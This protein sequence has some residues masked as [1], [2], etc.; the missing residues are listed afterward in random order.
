ML[1]RRRLGPS[2]FC[3]Y[4]LT[5]IYRAFSLLLSSTFIALWLMED[6]LFLGNLGGLARPL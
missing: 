4:D 5:K 3:L 6:K 2:F 1:R